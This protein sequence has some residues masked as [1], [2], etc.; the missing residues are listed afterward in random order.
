MYVGAY[1]GVP[2][3]ISLQMLA[4]GEIPEKG[5]VTIEMTS[6]SP[7]RYLEE[8]EKRGARLIKQEFTKG[9]SV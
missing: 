3:S 5:A 9:V 7:K 6:G 4:H 8:L 1:V 2:C